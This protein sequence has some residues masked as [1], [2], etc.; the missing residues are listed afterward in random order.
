MKDCIPF[1][2]LGELLAFKSVVD[3]LHLSVEEVA[4]G[5]GSRGFSREFLEEKACA[6]EK[7]G[8]WIPF[9]VV[10]SL[11]IYGVV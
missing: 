2:N 8:K 7:E 6:L 5:L 9:N 11:F 1:T 4:L 10:L 3:A